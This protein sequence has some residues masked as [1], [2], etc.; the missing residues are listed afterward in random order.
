[1]VAILKN[2]IAYTDS[3]YSPF[4][5]KKIV[6]AEDRPSFFCILYSDFYSAMTDNF[7]NRF[8]KVKMYNFFLRNTVLND[9]KFNKIKT[10]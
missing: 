6:M 9:K 4:Y 7:D 1:M 8:L 5:F 10:N 3:E 2:K